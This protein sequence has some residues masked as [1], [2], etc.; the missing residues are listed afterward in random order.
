MSPFDYNRSIF[1]TDSS[2]GIARTTVRYL[3][4][5]GFTVLAP[6]EDESEARELRAIKPARVRPLFPLDL[7]N[8][9]DIKSM[10][11]YIRYEVISKRLPPF[12]SLVHVS[13]GGH[14]TPVEMMKT[15]DIHQNLEK[16]I[17]GPILLLQQLIPMLRE[18][19]GRMLWIATLDITPLPFTAEVFGPD[20]FMNYLARVLRLE[21]LEDG[22]RS[23]L[24]CNGGIPKSSVDRSPE[25]LDLRFK[26]AS[27]PLWQRYQESLHKI[28]E[29]LA[30]LRGAKSDPE[31]V[32]RLV[33]MALTSR[34]PRNAYQM[35][36]MMD[37]SILWER[38]SHGLTDGVLKRKAPRQVDEP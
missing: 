35:G 29:G 20:H 31:E 33:G 3:A 14:L 10:V 1:I 19:Q 26:N 7:G 5:L 22:I 25:D 2:P 24:I 38:L 6:A 27:P 17:T 8:P 21:L 28:R 37:L 12:Y 15:E 11:H 32:A 18:S 36:T 4:D 16:R 34:S 23:I 13:G 30:R 9:E